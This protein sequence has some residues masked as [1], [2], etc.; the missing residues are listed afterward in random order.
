MF[1]IAAFSAL[2]GIVLVGSV[3][4]AHHRGYR[5]SWWTDGWC[6]EWSYA[7][8]FSDLAYR[9]NGVAYEPSGRYAWYPPG[10]V[11]MPRPAGERLPP[12]RE[13]R[14]ESETAGSRL[15]VDF[16]RPAKIK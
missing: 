3:A 5:N 2:A 10:T 13:G 12:P 14:I 16:T 7:G 11:F 9:Y 15:T 1:R 4:E 8:A 6:Y